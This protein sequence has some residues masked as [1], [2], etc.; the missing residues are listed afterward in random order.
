MYF[1]LQ[2][3]CCKCGERLQ[4]SNEPGI[5]LCSGACDQDNIDDTVEKVPSETGESTETQEEDI[6]EKL[7][8]L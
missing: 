7:G 6:D 4:N 5:H 1:T 8:M 2:D 3:T